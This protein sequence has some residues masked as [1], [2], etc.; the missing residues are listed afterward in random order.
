MKKYLIFVLVFFVIPIIIFAHQPNYINRQTKVIDTDPNIS[1]AYYGELFG[2]EAV[3]TIY[4]T[5]SLKLYIQILSPKIQDSN[6]DFIVLI[7]N[8]KQN[9]I[10]RLATS[11]D[12]WQSWYEEY[13]GDW[14][15]QGPSFNNIVSTGTY[16]I[17]VSR[18]NNIG[19]YTLA[20]GET[21][22]FPAKQFIHYIQEL[23][24]IKTNFF[25]EPWY[26]IFYGIIGKYL[27]LSSIIIIV[28][29]LVFIYLLKK[30]F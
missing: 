10:A 15:W 2:A 20:I 5:S 23:Y 13:G 7:V 22:S 19:K 12:G 25:N 29:V 3:Y 1:K 16:N 4:A 28:F 27:L 11:T 24:S 18:S 8:D 21:E 6:K 9:I 30:R 14:Y 26:G 17:I